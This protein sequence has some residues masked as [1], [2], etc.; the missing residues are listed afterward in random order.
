MQ[1]PTVEEKLFLL[2][3]PHL[4]LQALKNWELIKQE[5]FIMA[6]AVDEWS[7]GAAAATIKVE[8]AS[9]YEPVK[10]FGT[11][12]YFLRNYWDNVL[13]RK[14]LGNLTPMDAE[15]FCGRGFIQLTGRA[16]YEKAS[17]AIGVDIVKFPHLAEQ[18]ETAAKVFAWFWKINH[19]T[20]LCHQAGIVAR[21]FRKTIWIEVR[22]RINGGLNGFNEFYSTLELLELT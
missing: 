16:N 20:E 6:D 14:E 11:S 15:N 7:L 13:L 18:P 3:P 9:R 17:I 21:N 8:T 12:E 1:L 19:L 2:V 4:L 10:E 5:L 22:R